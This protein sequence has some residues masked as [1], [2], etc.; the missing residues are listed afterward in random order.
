MIAQAFHGSGAAYRSALR[1]AHASVTVARGVLA[2]ELRRAKVEQTLYASPP[3]GADVTT[4]YTSYPD[5]L[6][7]LVSAKPAPAWLGR[8]SVGFALSEVA[9]DRVFGL[10]TGRSAVIRTSSSAVR[11]PSASNRP[12]SNVDR[13]TLPDFPGDNVKA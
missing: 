7:R 1:H 4:F 13:V 6:V 11:G 10:R 3:S 8:K 5:L 9:P 12:R 2:D